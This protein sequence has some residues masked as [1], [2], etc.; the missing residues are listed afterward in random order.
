MACGR[1]KRRRYG[2]RCRRSIN[3]SANHDD[4]CRYGYER[5]P[6][7][8]EISLKYRDNPQLFIDNFAKAWFKLL[9]R[10]M[11]PKIR[12]LGP[13]F[14]KEDFICDPI[15]KGNTNYDVNSV[16]EKIAN[17]GLSISEMVE[18]AW[19]SASTFRGSD[20]RGGANGARIRLVSQKDWQAN[21][22]E[23]LAKVLGVLKIFLKKLVHLLQ[24]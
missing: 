17:S 14:P 10:D 5:D 12:Y 7:Y 23:Q 3:K 22:P 24:M 16:K 15:P 19:A 13:E 2:P 6:A 20:M 1:S 8:R 11:G 9:H 21:K 18:T 4:Y